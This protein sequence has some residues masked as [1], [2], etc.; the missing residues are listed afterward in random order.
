MPEGTPHIISA[1]G[2]SEPHETRYSLDGQTYTSKFAVV[3]LA[4]LRSLAGARA[5]LLVTEEAKRANYEPVA[6]ELLESG[7]NAMAVVIPDGR[8][9]AELENILLAVVGAVKSDE[10]IIL[11][12]T[13]GLRHLPFAYFTALT[14]LTANKQVT[15]DGIFYGAYELRDQHTNDTP[16]LDV[17]SLFELTQWYHALQSAQDTGSLG[18]LTGLLERLSKQLALQRRM[19]PQITALRAH[20]RKL[21]P[22]LMAGLPIEVG[23]YAQTLLATLDEERTSTSP[24]LNLSLNMLAEWGRGWSLPSKLDNEQKN[25]TLL[26]RGELE[27]QLNLAAWYTEHGAFPN[28]LLVLREWLINLV[29]FRTGK[30]TQWLEYDIRSPIEQWLND[31]NLRREANI[32]TPSE[33]ML[34]R[35]WQ[36]ISTRRN[37]FAHAGMDPKEVSTNANMLNVLQTSCRELLSNESL[38]LTPSPD[39]GRLLITPLG[40]SP[41]VLFSAL[42]LLQPDYLVVVTSAEAR[43]NVAT[44]VERADYTGSHEIFEVADPFADFRAADQ[45]VSRELNLRFIRSREVVVNLTGGTTVLQYV[46]D[47][48]GQKASRLGANVRRIALVDRR[49]PAEQQ[50]DPYETGELIELDAPEEVA[51]AE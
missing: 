47:Q 18:A 21:A 17:T 49:S 25:R 45:F 30:S 8:T 34:S 41:G 4:R 42:R 35:L 7:V 50:L 28:A 11:D 46:A 14:Y 38:A 40:R 43:E 6:H 13:A 36:R 10:Q 26:S 2:R 9:S 31:L 24:A 19:V 32:A 20:V 39:Q 44:A 15:I 37:D 29:L 51:H 1:I 12:L 33:L 3:A 5:T 27:R 23:M 48:F 22:A 16:L